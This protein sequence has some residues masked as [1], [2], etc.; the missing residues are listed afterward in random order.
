MSRK[1][2]QRGRPHLLKHVEKNQMKADELEN[3]LQ[4][5][6]IK[7]QQ[8]INIIQEIDGQIHIEKKQ[9]VKPNRSITA[10]PLNPMD[11]SLQPQP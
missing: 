8:T 1:I 3:A 5:A 4:I 2:I 7:H 6:K 11:K 9:T 10:P